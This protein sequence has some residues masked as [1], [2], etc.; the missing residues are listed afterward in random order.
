MNINNLTTG[1]I[2]W[3]SL[4]EKELKGE[5]GS[6]KYKEITSGGYRV[7]LAEYSANYSSAEWCD[8]GHILHCISGT[9]TL[10]LKNGSKI[11]LN[12][13]DSILLGS[14]HPHTATTGSTPA[15]LLI[16]D[17]E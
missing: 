11:V 2:D 6:T 9:L 17:N 13:G 8:K 7:R 5:N 10:H 15:V 1:K 14:T 12:V 4:P 16:I 3:K